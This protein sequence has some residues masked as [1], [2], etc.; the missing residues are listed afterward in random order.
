[1]ERTTMIRFSLEARR[2]KKG[3]PKG[4][5]DSRTFFLARGETRDRWEG[6]GPCVFYWPLTRRPEV[7]VEVWGPMCQWHELLACMPVRKE[8]RQEEGATSIVL[9]WAVGLRMWVRDE[10]KRSNNLPAVALSSLTFLWSNDALD[11]E[12]SIRFRACSLWCRF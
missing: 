12:D 4:E 6:R 1:M 7:F 3:K 10:F 5:G 11:R 8:H 9:L 2:I